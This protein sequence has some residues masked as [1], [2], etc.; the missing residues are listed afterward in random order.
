MTGDAD[1]TCFVYNVRL[2]SNSLEYVEL[3]VSAVNPIHDYSILERGI[4]ID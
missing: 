3:T 4:M 1:F 2:S